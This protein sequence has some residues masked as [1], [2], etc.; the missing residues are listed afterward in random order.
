MIF[1]SISPPIGY[2]KNLAVIGGVIGGIGGIV[3]GVIG[4]VEH[5]V[6]ILIYIRFLVIGGVGG[7]IFSFSKTF[8]HF[9]RKFKKRFFVSQYP[10]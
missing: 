9:S 3:G 6:K 2:E 10:Q 1:K 5:L 8:S 7:M 4:G